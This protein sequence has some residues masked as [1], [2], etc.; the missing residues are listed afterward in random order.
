[1]FN[2]IKKF[3]LVMPMLVCLFGIGNNQQEVNAANTIN[4]AK[5]INA[6]NLTNSASTST[7]VED[8]VNKDEMENNRLDFD[9]E[10]EEIQ[11]LFIPPIFGFCGISIAF[12]SDCGEDSNYSCVAAVQ[13]CRG[14]LI[15]HTECALQ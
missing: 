5:A 8:P 6:T 9:I 12:G 3:L 14:S 1:M 15:M 11:T 13:F 7:S 4:T 2:A 10:C